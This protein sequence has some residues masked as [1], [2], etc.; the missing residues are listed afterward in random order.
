MQ[1]L[2]VYGT[3]GV[4]EIPSSRHHVTIDGVTVPCG[5]EL[6]AATPFDPE[7]AHRDH[8]LVKVRAVSRPRLH[9]RR[10]EIGARTQREGRSGGRLGL[11]RRGRCTLLGPYLQRSRPLREGRL[12][13]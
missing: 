9:H 6:T 5:R 12:P 3:K 8:V 10:A 1:S 2:V 4:P 13:L 11:Q 7:R